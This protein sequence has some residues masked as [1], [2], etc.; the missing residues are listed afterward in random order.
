MGKRIFISKVKCCMLTAYVRCS[1]LL[2]CFF[3]ILLLCALFLDVKAAPV[4]LAE[5]E[6]AS[7]FAFDMFP[8]HVIAEGYSNF[9]VDAV[10]GNDG[11]LY[12]NIENLFK[13]LSIPCVIGDNR[14][15]LNGLIGNGNKIYSINYDTRQ[16]KVGDKIIPTKTGLFKET[17]A[18]YL[19]SSLFAQAFGI[20]LTFNFRALT[21]IVKSDFELPIFK[22][23]RIEKMRKNIAKL[24][25]EVLADTIVK[26]NYHLLKLGTLDWQAS[27]SQAGTGLTVN[28]FGL[29][30]GTEFLFGEADVSVNYSSQYK[31]DE[32]QLRYLWR[33]VDN[34]K[35][36]IK[37]AQLGK[38]SS[39][40][41]SYLKAPVVGAVIRNSP[42]TV[43][44]ARGYYTIQDHTEPN[45]SVELYVNDILVDYA[46]ADASGLYVF[47]VP[48]IYGYT[49]LRLKFYG[50]M[51]EERTE[52][53]TMN[54]PYT[55]IPAKDFDYSLSGGIVQ[56]SS[57]SRFGKGEFNYGVNRFITL[58][59]GLEYLSSIPNVP[60]IPY[61]KITIQPF[62]KLILNVEYAHGVKTRGL[63]N[64]YFGN[65]TLL[66][67]DYTKYVPGQL[68][69]LFNA[70][71]ERK[72]KL[73]LPFRIK[74]FS[75]FAK[76][77]Y[78][79]LV[80]KSYDYNLGNVMLS[81][82]YKQFS[83][84]SSTQFNW[85]DQEN[86]N[87]IS[88]LALSYRLK[89]GFQIRSSA[90]VNAV[91]NTLINYNASVEKS[92]P[93]GNISIS[94]RRNI[95][96][97]ANLISL[98]LKYDLPFA[99]TN[100]SASQNNGNIYT[101][102]SARGSLAFGSGNH[103]I[104]A[105]S[106]FSVGKGGIS[107]FPFLDL[108]NNGVFDKSEHLVKLNSVRV[109][110]GHAIYS[111]KDSIVRIPDLNSFTS[112]KVE[113]DDNDLGNIAWR[114]KKK[115]YQVLI[116]PNQFKRINIPVV[117]IGEISGMAYMKTDSLQ[118]GIGRILVN[119]Y[120]KN[121][122]EIVA[123]T[124]SES[125]GYIYYLGFEPGEYL[126]R[127]DTGQLN[128]LNFTADPPQIEFTIKTL[129]E[130]DIV[131]GIDFVLTDNTIKKK[132][133][134]EISDP[135]EQ[136][137][138][139]EERILAGY[140][141]TFV[142]YKRKIVPVEKTFIPI[143][144][145]T[146]LN[147]KGLIYTI[148]L[149]ES[150]TF[151]NPAYFEEKFN[152]TDRAWYFWQDGVY[153]YVTGKYINEEEAMADMVQL[154]LPGFITVTVPSKVNRSP[155]GNDLIPVEKEIVPEEEIVP[156]EKKT[157]YMN[158]ETNYTVQLAA[159]KTYIDPDFYKKKFNLTDVW[160]F[161]KDGYFKY[162]TGKYISK[163]E[164]NDAMVQHGIKGF[165][166][167]V[168]QLKVKETSNEI[169]IV[170]VKAASGPINRTIAPSE[171]EML[172]TIQLAASKTYI[173]PTFYRKKFNLT[174]VWY[175]EKDGY[176]KYATGKYINKDEANVGMVQFGITGFVTSVDPLE[177]KETP[178]EKEIIPVKTASVPIEKA[179]ATNEKG[180]IYTIQLA[181]SKTY[182][183][184]DFF[185]KKFNLTDVF[186]FEKDGYFKYATGKYISKNE[187]NS[188]IVQYGIKGFVTVVDR[189]KVKV[190]STGNEIVP[191]TTN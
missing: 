184:P 20:T 58:G 33:W 90:Q 167:V 121:S 49:T 127:V 106:N 93:K 141:N 182:I 65:N 186:Y 131:D 178:V 117:S 92:I 30:I 164:A 13:S 160:Y 22:Q 81:A 135:F 80:Y 45:W 69:T 109:S 67:F 165:V 119:F 107:I 29:G 41:I 86:P 46:K 75:G 128:N 3:T 89:K 19:E 47:K 137:L 138:T 143:K 174:D 151:V 51:G 77:D 17:G 98:R 68:V 153:N 79:Q 7:S 32:R 129:K 21:I 181:A 115:V 84:N 60:F 147:T 11:L 154:G 31:F 189:S 39:Q 170:P 163:N 105:R 96:N 43:R 177:V 83:A 179:I 103:N 140:G 113:F 63:L 132:P 57:S 134:K 2:S 85:I 183:D 35:K 12:V 139:P 14:D 34:D 144:K 169:E 156:V 176:F 36:F 187:A 118:E 87:V 136:E 150:R 185:K 24:N 27:S 71:E 130:G 40:S 148:Q 8:V 122:T 145:R 82:Y 37:Q 26:R 23:M 188:A 110:G 126:A 9:Y 6:E 166:T 52:E 4:T 142:P 152:L 70:P 15:I 88:D 95:K 55:I 59:G 133:D 123:K 76:L 158:N 38:I 173:D 155:T 125:D 104:Q 1:A 10:Y 91:E 54:V 159:S 101:S 25:G 97:S 16:I 5:G 116:D 114:F 161:E 172:Y 146:L 50:T 62:S 157:V 28:Q 18:L 171:K 53:R 44:K 175:F 102:E 108:N 180:I 111:M 190:T 48:I 124:L 112:Y 72:V 99:R 120:K 191:N 78:T 94:Y 61:T 73:S 74:M 56:D 149:S 162:V 66:E 168:G 42:T 64:Y 100:V